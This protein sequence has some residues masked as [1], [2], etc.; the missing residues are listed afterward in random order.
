[1]IKILH[2]VGDSK[3]GGGSKVVIQIAQMALV[4]GWKVDVLT[5]DPVFQEKLRENGI[6]IISLDCIWRPIRPFKDFFGWLRLFRFLKKSD[7]TLVHTHTSKAGF[8]GRAAAWY[9]RIPVIIHTVHGFAFHEESSPFSLWFFSNLERIASKWCHCLVTVSNFH[10]DWAI[11]LHIAEPE[12]IVAIPNGIS[13]DDVKPRKPREETRRTLGIQN[14]HIMLLTMGRLAPQKG[15]EYLLEALGKLKKE[16][17]IEKIVAIIVGEGPL[18]KKLH[19]MARELKIEDYVRFLG[20]RQDVGDLLAA[21]DI[22]VLPSLREGLSI[23]LLEAMAAGKPIITT[24]IGSNT[25]ASSNGESALL[26]PAK[27]SEKLSLAM[28]EFIEQEDNRSRFSKAAKQNYLDSYQ[29]NRTIRSYLHLYLSFL[30]KIKNKG[31]EYG[32]RI[33]EDS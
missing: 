5:T 7:Y 12:K 20:F 33:I 11:R 15:L 1:M 18:Q 10:R 29:I 16:G 4:K 28:K 32:G 26:I 23:A 2:I 21:S 14:N 3:F 22:V 9:A 25:E 24:N 30:R 27:D 8:I 13:E 6:G 31:L 19:Q 17:S